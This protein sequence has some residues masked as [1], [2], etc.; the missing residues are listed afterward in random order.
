MSPAGYLDLVVGNEDGELIYY[1]N[2]GTRFVLREGDD[3]PFDDIDVDDTSAPALGDLNNDGTL[4]W[5][6]SVDR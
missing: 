6:A 5:T 3:N 4:I 1:E 2:T